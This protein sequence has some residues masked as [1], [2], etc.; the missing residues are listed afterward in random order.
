MRLNPLTAIFRSIS[1]RTGSREAFA[2]IDTSALDESLTLPDTIPVPKGMVLEKGGRGQ[3]YQST[4]SMRMRPKTTVLYRVTVTNTGTFT[5]PSFM[6]TAYGKPLKVPS[7]TLTVTDPIP[8]QAPRSPAL[9]VVIPSEVY[10]GQMVRVLLVLPRGGE[11]SIL[12]MNQGK[13]TGDAIFSEPVSSYARIEN[14]AIGGRSENVMVQEVGVTPLHAGEQQILAQVFGVTIKSDPAQPNLKRAV[15]ELMDSDPVTIRVKPLPTNDVPAGFTGAIGSF[16][17]GNTLVRPSQP[18]AGE[19]I[20]LTVQIRGNGNLG[21]L[22]PPV[23]PEVQ[24]WQV[25]P[26]TSDSTSSQMIQQRGFALFNYTLIPLS[27]SLIAT[28]GIPFAYFDPE[29]GVYKQLNFPPLSIHVLPGVVQ[30]VAAAIPLPVAPP[31]ISETNEVEVK[32]TLSGLSASPGT[33]RSLVPVQSRRGFWLAQV[34]IALAM[35]ALVGWEYRRRYLEANPEV[36]WK[37]R[38]RR[39]V[40]RELKLARRA[41]DARDPLGFAQRAAN[42]LREACAPN[43]AANPQALVCA[44]VLGEVGSVNISGKQTQEVVRKIFVAADAGRFGGNGPEGESVLE[45]RPQWEE[46]VGVLRERL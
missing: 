13:V 39:G 2:V 34:L 6:I 46:L 29:A 27:E 4:P 32:L 43:L 16:Q 26:A 10:V 20:T 14:R 22:A 3:T 1:P 5:I 24:N 11:D 28:P 23:I 36:V 15:S 45:L 17:L 9:S 18:H 35:G 8:G 12:G 42:V 40:R 7:T 41:A 33:V 19:P 21:R 37:Q 44:D 25:F 30:P 38:A 31:P